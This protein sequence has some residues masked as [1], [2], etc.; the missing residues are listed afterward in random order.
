M[1]S[2]TARAGATGMAISLCS[3][4]ERSLLKDIQR[5]TRQTQI[6]TFDR[7]N[8]KVLAQATAVAEALARP[9][10]RGGH[11]EGESRANRDGAGPPGESQPPAAGPQRGPIRVPTPTLPAPAT[12]ARAAGG[13]GQPGRGGGERAPKAITSGSWSPL[14][15]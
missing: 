13:R 5:A 7:R 9:R 6:P 1:I 2:R 3:D 8:D 14:D 11:D 12:P 4:D 10:S 15:S